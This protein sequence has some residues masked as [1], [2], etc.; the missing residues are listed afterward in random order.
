MS[1]VIAGVESHLVKPFDSAYAK[2]DEF[3]ERI[4][5]NQQLLLKEEAYLDKVADPAA[6]SYYIENLTASLADEAWKIFLEIEQEGGYIEAVKSS[7]IQQKVKENSESLNHAIA[8]REMSLLGTNE[9]PNFTER[10]ETYI[11]AEVFKVSDFTEEDAVFETLKL[12]RGSQAFEILRKRT[13]DHSREHDRPAVFMFTYGNL[14]MRIAR[15]QFASNFFAVAG[16][17]LIDNLGFKTVKDG[18]KAAIDSKADIVVICSSDE[19][20]ANIVPDIIGQ[21]KD[22]AIVV[23][24][25]YPKNI[26]EDLKRAGLK[27]FIHMRSNVLESLQQMQK[28]LGI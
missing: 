28:E 21:L 20:Y 15:A 23:L 10:I 9:Y 19:E 25:G 18:V 11:P 5:R 3:S 27:H 2:P 17:D 24:A 1:A 12:Y 16:F 4:A 13:D 26:I 8:S 14:S 7:F 6:G 22:K